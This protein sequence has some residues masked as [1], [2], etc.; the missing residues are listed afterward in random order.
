MFVRLFFGFF[1]QKNQY[2]NTYTF[3]LNISSSVAHIIR[4]RCV[5][6]LLTT[7]QP[8]SQPPHKQRRLLN[9]RKAI[10][11]VIVRSLWFNMN[12]TTPSAELQIANF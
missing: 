12:T 1:L 4:Q 7:R 10:N 2:K 6:I 3:T 9:A 8:A 11:C 5:S